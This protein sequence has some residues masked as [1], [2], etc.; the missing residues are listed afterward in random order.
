MI[1]KNKK[2]EYR[3]EG[4]FIFK[5]YIFPKLIKI[6]FDYNNIKKI[7]KLVIEKK[8][9][10]EELKQLKNLKKCKYE[11]DE[12]DEITKLAKRG[13]YYEI[14]K[15]LNPHLD[16]EIDQKT[17]FRRKYLNR[18]CEIPKDRYRGHDLDLPEKQGGGKKKSKKSKKSRRSKKTKRY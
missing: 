2:F 1:I 15:K 3:G 9:L 16:K 12:N 5:D 10:K 11:N 13:D 18:Y 7:K 14:S 4:G 17:A 8:S 6:K